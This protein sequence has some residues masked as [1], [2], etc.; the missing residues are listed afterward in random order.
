MG[1]GHTNSGDCLPP[2]GREPRTRGV[3]SWGV[4]SPGVP[5]PAEN[6]E[7]Q[8]HQQQK[9]ERAAGPPRDTPRGHPAFA[10]R[11]QYSFPLPPA[12]SRASRSAQR[13][14]RSL[15]RSLVA[16]LPGQRPAAPPPA[17]RAGRDRGGTSARSP[18]SSSQ[19][20]GVFLP[21][22]PFPSFEGTRSFGSSFPERNMQTHVEVLRTCF[23]QS[24]KAG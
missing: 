10:Q 6:Q 14:R 2:I 21:C 18:G 8:D 24:L 22:L 4:C 3:E 11:A 20:H 17:P 15:S 19:F 1:G 5:S 12:L 16:W 7:T 23:N 13:L 9:S